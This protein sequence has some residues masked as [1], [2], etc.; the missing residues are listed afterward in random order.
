MW[1]GTKEGLS[2]FDGSVFKNF[3][4]GTINNNSL[5]G[6]AISYLNEY[7]PGHLLFIS[8]GKLTCMNTFTGTFYSP[9]DFLNKTV[10]WMSPGANNKYFITKADTCFIADGQLTIQHTLLPPI[11]N[12]SLTITVN[13]LDSIHLLVGNLQEYYL[14]NS[15]T[16]D[17]TSF[18]KAADYS[19]EQE[20]FI[21]QYY[22][23]QNKWLYF[24]NFYLGLFRFNLNHQLLF[25][26]K[27]GLPPTRLP[28]ANISF[29]KPKK[30]GLLWIGSYDGGLTILDTKTNLVQQVANKAGNPTS[31]LSNTVVNNYTD[32][33][34]NEWLAT[35][36]GVSKLNANA[37]TIK[38]WRKEFEPANASSTLLNLVKGSDNSLYVSFYGLPYCY[39]VHP[40]ADAITMLD[41]NKLPN[42]WCMN[43]MGNKIIFTGGGTSVTTY[44]PVSGTYQKND[45]LKKYFPESEVVILAFKQRNGDE[46]YSGNKGGGFVRVSA[47]DGA[48][49]TYKKD[50]TNGTFSISYYAYSVEDKNG[51]LWFGVNKSEKLLY[52]DHAK[53]H[54]KEIAFDTVKGMTNPFLT[55]IADLT[56]DSAN[57]IWIAFEG[58]GIL[59]YDPVMHI[60]RQYLLTDGLPTNYV[61]AIQF[62]GSNRLWIGTTKGMS[63]LLVKENKFISFTTDDGLPEDFFYERCKLYDSSSNM[64]WI[65]AK[66]TLMRF[67]P[68][69]L[70]QLR[71]KKIP[72]YFDE[73]SVN[74][75]P[76]PALFDSANNFAPE[77]NNF[78]FRFTAIDINNGRDIEY[79]YQLQGA[80]ISWL[81]A[82]NISTASYANL[83]PGNYKFLVRARHKGNNEWG[84]AVPLSF[85]IQ[86]PWFKT[87]W[88]K[89]LMMAFAIIITWLLIRSYYSR[90]LEKEKLVLE[91]QQ[92]VEKERT[93]IATDMH[94]DFGANLSRIKFIS[95]K[96]QLTVRKDDNL[97]N[98]LVK[99]SVYSDEMAEKMNEIVWAL[100]Q[101]YDSLEDLLSF[102]RAYAQELLS[103]KNI[104]CHFS[105]TIVENIQLN[106]EIRRNI[107]LVVKECLNNIIK[108][109]AAANV[110]ISFVQKDK[111]YVEVTDNGKGIDLNNIRPF[112]NGLHNMKQRMESINGKMEICSKYG[113]TVKLECPV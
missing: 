44:D 83:N 97:K 81:N 86:T 1:F 38:S 77:Q 19:T 56:I 17:Y 103:E 23:P 36:E 94:D 43:R 93:R 75:K 16:K 78:Q 21:F 113:T 110:I 95:E 101:R 50:G 20:N 104:A 58:A 62:D 10:Y 52:W 96:I 92:A 71:D 70:L 39:V 49:H 32:N 64:L 99:I 66:N 7:K 88:F 27:P 57:N 69:E 68:G 61:N 67:N 37:A 3:F 84:E 51:N 14:Y 87:W 42:P 11:K 18:V 102:T 6:N 30:N 41:K 79:S 106:G 33:E 31:L 15:I 80:D 4:S 2:R 85:I 26:W 48:V 54:F 24:S 40:T 5:K 55:G 111:L 91:K 28:G 89:L 45:F 12:K 8:A 108:H 100:N 109:A 112:A 105:S 46:W 107:F 90:K 82:G 35:S 34:Q 29:I 25:Q 74:G 53:D 63:C 73:I 22:D 65:G 9:T 72:V 98:D 76:Y 59:K 60:A 47:T 13:E